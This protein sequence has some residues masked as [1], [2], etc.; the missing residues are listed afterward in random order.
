MIVMAVDPGPEMSAWVLYDSEEHCV[1][2]HGHHTN[3]AVMERITSECFGCF[4]PDRREVVFEKVVSY[5]MPV[6]EETFETVFWT[7]IMY[8]TAAVSG[9]KV[10]RLPRKQVCL[11]LCQSMKARDTHIRQALLD[12]F[13]G[14]TAIG[15]KAKPGPLYGLRSHGFAALAVAVTWADT[16]QEG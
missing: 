10:S 14:S 7:G 12:R 6:G 8:C 5:G 15:V 13:G 11:H 3:Q 2:N 9:A 1:L 16:H 4:G